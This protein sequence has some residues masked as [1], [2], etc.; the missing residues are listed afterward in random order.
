[1][2]TE[3][4]RDTVSYSNSLGAYGST[5]F[6]CGGFAHLLFL[7]MKFEVNFLFIN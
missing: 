4:E 3:L 1:M 2:I 5:N 7:E 6:N